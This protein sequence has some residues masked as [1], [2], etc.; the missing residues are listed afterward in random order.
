MERFWCVREGFLQHAR[1]PT[2][3]HTICS[4]KHIVKRGFKKC[5]INVALDGNRI[6][7]RTS[8]KTGTLA[9]RTRP[10]RTS[11]AIVNSDETEDEDFGNDQVVVVRRPA[12]VDY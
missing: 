10:P 9:T 4:N 6:A 3:G 5:G 12:F 2:L 1:S 8:V 11:R 7:M